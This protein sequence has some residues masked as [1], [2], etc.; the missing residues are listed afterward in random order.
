MQHILYDAS[1]FDLLSRLLP[2]ELR[3]DPTLQLIFVLGRYSTDQ[4]STPADLAP[5]LAR[6]D[7]MDLSPDWAV[8]AFG[9]GET[10]CLCEANRQGGKMR[11]GFENSLWNP[12][13]ELALNNADRVK[14]LLRALD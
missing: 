6:M 2:H 1:D 5:F 3:S 14:R 10:N 4:N 7:S 12:D 11:I 9:K 13:G 8:C